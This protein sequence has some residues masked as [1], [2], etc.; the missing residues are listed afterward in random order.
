MAGGGRILSLKREPT[1]S[2]FDLNVFTKQMAALL[3]VGVPIDQALAAQTLENG[4]PLF[5]TVCPQLARYIQ[6]GHPLS[7]ALSRYP[8]IFSYSYVALVKAAE[9]SGQL[10]EALDRIGMWL[11]G[12]DVVLRRIKSAL[13]YPAF[14]V[15]LS[16]VLTFALF[17]T[18]IPG[19]LDTVRGMGVE[20]PLPTL[21]LSALVTAAGQPLVWVLFAAAM[22]GVVYYLRTPNGQELVQ[23]LASELPIVRPIFVNTC[24]GR[25]S[26]TLALLCATGVD[27][28]QGTTIA[29]QASG[30]LIL[31][32]DS[33]RVR[34]LLMEGKTLSYSIRNQP[35]YPHILQQLVQ[36]AE[37]TGK[38]DALLEQAR[39]V[40]EDDAAFRLEKLTALLEPVILAGLSVFVGSILIAILMPLVNLAG[41]L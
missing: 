21:I 7:G 15:V 17:R 23:Q 1:C 41:S 32:E 35:M 34:R 20:L 14:V 26:S 2:N 4:S 13:T 18:V 10:V 6:S 8:R 39:K 40:L 27:L 33:L 31:K 5:R 38:F 36:V 37:Q 25:Y 16:G 19:I 28:L 29:A 3:R 24:A 9:T 30:S 22:G 12:S 11:D